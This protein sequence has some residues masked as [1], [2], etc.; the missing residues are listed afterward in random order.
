MANSVFL[1]KAESGIAPLL[2][3]ATYAEIQSAVTGVGSQL[4]NSLPDDT[5]TAVLNVIIE[6]MSKAYIGVIAGG[7]LAIVL[8]LLMKRERLFMSPTAAA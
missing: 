5:R 7:A 1:N 4:V 3:N 8:S 2:P 6:A